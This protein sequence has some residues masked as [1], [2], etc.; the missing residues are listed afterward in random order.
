ML[1]KLKT[2]ALVGIDAHPVEAEEEPKQPPPVEVE[3]DSN[4]GEAG[5]PDHKA[6]NH[7]LAL[8]K[9]EQP[10]PVYVEEE[11]NK[12]ANLSKPLLEWG[13]DTHTHSANAFIHRIYNQLEYPSNARLREGKYKARV[14][15]K[16]G[17]RA[18]LQAFL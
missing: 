18:K 9:P 2:Y 4:T 5:E 11:S 15:A 16:G 3:E 13:I 8:L 17:Q 14:G 6:E 10:N 12:E 7:L 1:A